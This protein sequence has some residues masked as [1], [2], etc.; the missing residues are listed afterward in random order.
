M[1]AWLSVWSEVQT[2]IWSSRCHCHSLSLASLKSRLVLPFWYWL[3][4]VVSDKGPLNGC[5]CPVLPFFFLP[6]PF[7]FP[8]FSVPLS[9][10]PFPV[11]VG[12][13]PRLHLGVWGIAQAPLAGPGGARPPNAFSFSKTRLVTTS[14]VLLCDRV[15]CSIS[16]HITTRQL[17]RRAST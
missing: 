5:V 12:P 9:F 14:L 7:T 16:G 3:T 8:S 2:C 11:E 10:L 4:R 15:I 13:L 17:P 1:L 6:L